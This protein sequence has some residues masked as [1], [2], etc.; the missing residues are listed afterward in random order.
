MKYLLSVN[1]SRKPRE[2]IGKGTKTIEVRRPHVT[3]TL[4]LMSRIMALKEAVKIFT[5]AS[6]CSKRSKQPQTTCKQ[7]NNKKLLQN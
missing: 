3:V 6:L 1:E 2:R 7:F 4:P 5:S